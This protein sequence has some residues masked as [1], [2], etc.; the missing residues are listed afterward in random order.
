MENIIDD[1]LKTKRKVK[2]IRVIFDEN[3]NLS[4]E[5]Y[6]KDN[7]NPNNSS[8]LDQI[9]IIPVERKN[10]NTEESEPIEEDVEPSECSL[11]SSLIRLM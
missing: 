3:S 1:S 7:D 5:D 10:A 9:K 6:K 4:E 2:T 8:E 11:K